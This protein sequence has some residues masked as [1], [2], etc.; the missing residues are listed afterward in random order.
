M[1][2]RCAPRAFYTGTLQSLILYIEEI[3][4]KWNVHIFNMPT[5]DFVVE[6]AFSI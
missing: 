6:I 4:K 5:M 2:S 3:E 1:Y